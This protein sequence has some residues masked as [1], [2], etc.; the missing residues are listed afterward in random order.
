VSASVSCVLGGA[1]IAD[2]YGKARVGQLRSLFS[3]V[4]VLST[5][6]TPL[7]FGA[8]LDVGI[9]IGTLALSSEVVLAGAA[10]NSLRL[11]SLPVTSPC[12]P[13][14]AVI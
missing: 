4:M 8:L 2:V 9:S 12:A 13:I 10:L 6:I 5:A 7:V 14:P 11:W 3:M 1:I